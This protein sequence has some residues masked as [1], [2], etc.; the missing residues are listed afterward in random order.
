MEKN[1][2]KIRQLRVLLKSII[3]CAG[4]TEFGGSGQY[5]HMPGRGVVLFDRG[6]IEI[7]EETQFKFMAT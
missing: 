5:G 7:L 4:G 6:Q 2:V 3:A 1:K